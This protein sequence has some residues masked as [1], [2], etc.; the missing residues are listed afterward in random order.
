MSITV[1]VPWPLLAT[2][3]R[4]PF[5]EMTMFQGSAPVLIVPRRRSTRALNRFALA[6]VIRITVTVPDPAFA[7]YA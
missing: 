6:L 4:R 1:I 2:N 3:T 5:G 7:T